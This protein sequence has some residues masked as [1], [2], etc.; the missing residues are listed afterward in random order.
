LA[1]TIFAFLL[2]FEDREYLLG[3][4]NPSDR[5]VDLLEQPPFFNG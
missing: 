3:F 2:G 5:A 1:R 4:H